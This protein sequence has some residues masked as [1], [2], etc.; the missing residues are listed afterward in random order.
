MSLFRLGRLSEARREFQ[1]LAYRHEFAATANFFLGRIAYAQ[2]RFQDA[3]KF[4]A[5][6]VRIAQSLG[7]KAANEYSYDYGLTLFRLGRYAEASSQFRSATSAYPLNPSP[8]MMRGRCEEELGN[9]AAA[10]ASYEESIRLDPNIDRSYY[11]L[12]RL[13]QRYGDPKRAAELF[14]WIEKRR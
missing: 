6:A 13:H 12:A 14:E 2:N 1:P 3:L 5:K 10:I 9:F 4:F 8:W 11:H 7:P